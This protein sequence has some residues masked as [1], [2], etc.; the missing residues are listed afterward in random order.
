MGEL[1]PVVNQQKR[2]AQS[3]GYTGNKRTTSPGQKKIQEQY[4]PNMFRDKTC[5]ELRLS[6]A[7]KKVT[8]AGWVQRIRKMGGMTFIDIRDRYGITQ[9]VLDSENNPELFEKANSLGRE[10]VMECGKAS[11]LKCM[12]L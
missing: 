11:L 9:V 3:D 8:I 6:D 2:Y 5:G 4:T 1:R 7:G 10:Y 12:Q